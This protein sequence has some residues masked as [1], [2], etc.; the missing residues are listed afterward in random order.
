MKKRMYLASSIIFFMVLGSSYAAEKERIDI[1][2]S[3]GMIP[4][5]TELAKGYMTE[6]RDVIIAVKQTSIQ[7]S[8]GISGAAAGSLQIGMANRALNDEEK[9]LGLEVTNIALVGVV[10]AVNKS[11]PLREI[12]SE[13]LCNIYEGKLTDW[14]ELGL[15]AGKIHV[16]T[17]SEKDAT[18]ETIRKSIAC[19]RNLKE[20]ASVVV[21]PSSP[22]MKTALSNSKSLGLTDSMTVE[23]SRGV[24]VALKLDGVD[25]NTDNI[26]SGKYKIVQTYR[27]VTKG[28]PAGA[29]KSFLDFIK[30]PKGRKII[31]DNYAI[32]VK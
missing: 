24:I 22:E 13:A 8:G 12:S 18:K 32:A 25:P 5:V 20:P 21:V 30:G 1:A 27:L 9:Q 19:F 26:K 23:S 29:V 2:G 28:K 16:I 4:L 10:A 6:N 3:G 7:S 15:P 17:K 11:I 31:E 14:G